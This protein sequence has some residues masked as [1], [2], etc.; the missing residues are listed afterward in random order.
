MKTFQL[1][2]HVELPKKSLQ[3]IIQR[4]NK[5][6]NGHISMDIPVLRLSMFSIHVGAVFWL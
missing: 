4:L 3:K 5:N 6:D 1:I 2:F